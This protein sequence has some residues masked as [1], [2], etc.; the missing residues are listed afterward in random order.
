MLVWQKPTQRPT[1]VR[2]AAIQTVRMPVGFYW[3][4][5]CCPTFGPCVLGSKLGWIFRLEVYS[6]TET[7]MRISLSSTNVNMATCGIVSIY[8]W[9][10]KRA[11]FNTI[12]RQRTPPCL[13]PGYTDHLDLMGIKCPK[14]LK[15]CVFFFPP[16]NLLFLFN[17]SIKTSVPT[18][19]TSTTMHLHQQPVQ[20][21]GS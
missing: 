17:N 11:S 7:Q 14:V 21:D 6:S 4:G 10:I 5:Q 1:F 20:L 9:N 19:T 16:S 8:A 2:L 18:V 12:C 15:C 3:I 13:S